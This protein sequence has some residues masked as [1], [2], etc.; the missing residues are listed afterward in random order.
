M[1]AFRTHQTQI[2]FYA[3]TRIKLKRLLTNCR[4]KKWLMISPNQAMFLVEA[5]KIISTG[6]KSILNKHHRTRGYDFLRCDSKM[7]FDWWFSL[8]SQVK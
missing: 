6:N 4:P 5:G 7:V 3:L 8:V 2:A 1:R